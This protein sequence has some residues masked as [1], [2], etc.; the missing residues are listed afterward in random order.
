MVKGKNRRTVQIAILIGVLLLGGYAIGKTLFASTGGVPEVGGKP[1]AFELAGIDGAVHDLNDYRGKPL[2]INFWG[3]F[4]P[5]CVAEM[6]AF[7]EQYNKWKGQ[8]LEVLAINLSEDDLTVNSF[9]QRFDL[10]YTIL[11]D[12]NRIVEKQYGLRSY[13]TTFFIQPDGTIVD[14]YVGGM[15]AEDIEQRI[16]RLLQG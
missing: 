8:G 1:P 12:K 2:V 10:D 14:I 3:S 9:L 4:C 11:R 13:P 7:Q 6:P 5:P 15:T 16:E